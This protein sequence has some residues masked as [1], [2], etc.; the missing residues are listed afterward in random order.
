MLLEFAKQNHQIQTR[1]NSVSRFNFEGKTYAN[2]ITPGD[3]KH[4]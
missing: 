2:P 1:D 3:G 4:I